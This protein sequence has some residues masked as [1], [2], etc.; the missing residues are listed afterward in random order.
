MRQRG[1]RRIERLRVAI[2]AP[3]LR[4]DRAK[5]LLRES[6][7]GL[8]DIAIELGF[9]S[10]SHFTQVFRCLVGMTPSRFREVQS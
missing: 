10:Q 4:V 6:R 7:L 8:V 3:E 5:T 2:E 9:C 1:G